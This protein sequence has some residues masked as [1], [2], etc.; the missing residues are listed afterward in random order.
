MLR[1]LSILILGFC[2]Q[3]CVAQ[4]VEV[5]RD[6][7][8]TSSDSM[9]IMKNGKVITIESYAQRYQPRKALLYS[10]VFP[11]LGQAYNKKYWKLP[12]VYGGFGIITAVVITYNQLY[13]E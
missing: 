2:F 8:E 10:A 6:S 12:I 4:K 3:V 1:P 9:R 5:A 7:V 11:G 13:V